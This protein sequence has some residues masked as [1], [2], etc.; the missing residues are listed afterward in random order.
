M[1]LTDSDLKIAVA[2]VRESAKYRHVSQELITRLAAREFSDQPN[3]KAV[4]KETKN[5]L[6]LA[7]GAYLD[8]TPNYI[9]WFA[10]IEQVE[11][12]PLLEESEED[13]YRKLAANWMRSHA[14]TRER[15]P[16]LESYYQFPFPDHG[17]PVTS[18][19]DI[20]CGL[21]P[22]A[23]PWMGLPAGATYHAFDLY[24]D[25]MGFINVYL[26]LIGVAGSAQ[27]RDC[28]SS[29][30]EHEADLALILKFLPVLEQIEKGSTLAWLKRLNVKR[31]LISFPTRTLGGRGIGME[32]SYETRFLQT[33]QDEPW[34]VQ[35]RLFD[36]ELC[37][38]VNRFPR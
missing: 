23:I 22:L 5:R 28:V 20:A 33:I 21:N 31:M 12:E 35:K 13:Q 10:Q 18:V 6:H 8:A 19:L 37:F 2:A 30:P 7:A 9:K 38:L 11:M 15:L 16:L 4:I 36:N 32:E 29:P 14:S 26:D 24:A 17:E 34:T 3:L 27:A 25:M 1:K